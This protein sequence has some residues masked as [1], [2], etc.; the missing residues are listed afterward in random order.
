[1]T[2][3]LT[4]CCRDLLEFQHGVIARWQ[5]AASEQDLVAL[6][7]LLRSGRW[8]QLYRGVY[9]SFTGD[10]P[11]DCLL[12]AAVLRTGPDAV[13]SHHTAAELDRLTDRPSATLHVTVG[14]HRRI[15]VSG[16]WQ[17]E[18]ALPIVIH[19]SERVDQ[20]RHP[21]RRPP[22]TRIE[23]TVLD[24]T[25]IAASFDIAFGWLSAGCGRR[26]VTPQ[27]LT[28]AIGKRQHLRWRSEM[29]AAIGT[30]ADGVHSSLEYRYVGNVERAHA[31]PKARRQVRSERRGRAQYADN[32][33]EEYGLVVE[34]DGQA[35]HLV[36]DRW[37]DIHRDNHNA[38]LGVITL[39][40][41][42]ADVTGRPCEVAAEIAA[43]LRMRGWAGRLTSC[44]PRC[45]AAVQ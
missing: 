31:L 38:R 39:R 4:G 10:P 43:V 6:R 8:Q 32:V 1:M 5:V 20:A 18:L 24:L 33:Y 9:A 26:L 44:G 19:R 40:Y 41:S 13:L 22:R 23:E 34:V 14:H 12:W 21:V 7:G 42:W 17:H 30:I 45:Q 11:R 36:Q 37:H 28:A 35:S 29:L 27:V 15:A 25:Q 3:T 16:Q 2:G